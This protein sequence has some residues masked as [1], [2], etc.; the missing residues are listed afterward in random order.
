MKYGVKSPCNLVH[1]CSPEHEYSMN[2]YLFQTYS[3][4]CVGEYV[5]G[6]FRIIRVD[7]D[8]IAVHFTFEYSGTTT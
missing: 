7:K 6:R 1:A 2:M 8:S 4:M 5:P 3:K